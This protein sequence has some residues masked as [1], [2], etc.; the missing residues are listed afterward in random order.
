MQ[1]LTS[2]PDSAM[3]DPGEGAGGS[4]C[5][6]RLRNGWATREG[7]PSVGWERMKLSR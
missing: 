3:K 7:R 6:V 4:G 1:T 2:S 5:F